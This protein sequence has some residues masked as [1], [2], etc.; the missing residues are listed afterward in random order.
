[1]QKIHRCKMQETVWIVYVCAHLYGLA[2]AALSQ[3]LSMD[4]V[5]RSEY[6]VH[7]V[8]RDSQ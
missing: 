5:G 7:A 4:Q 6:S 2:E 1:M 3:D 8:G